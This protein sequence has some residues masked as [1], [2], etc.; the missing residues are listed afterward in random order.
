MAQFVQFL[1]KS[2][3]VA[4]CSKECVSTVAIEKLLCC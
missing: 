1:Q 2:D 4:E 3:K